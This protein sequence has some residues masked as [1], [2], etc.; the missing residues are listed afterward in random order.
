MCVMRL[1]TA[2]A[3]A[4]VTGAGAVP[5]CATAAAARPDPRVGGRQQIQEG[6]VDGAKRQGRPRTQHFYFYIFFDRRG[7]TPLR[8]C[9]IVCANEPGHGPTI[10]STR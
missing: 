3:A 7:K 8:V 6:G 2:A 4:A 1:V 10:P 9:V 5:G